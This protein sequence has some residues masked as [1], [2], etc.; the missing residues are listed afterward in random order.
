MNRLKEQENGDRKVKGLALKSIALDEISEVE[1][2]EDNAKTLNMLT[3]KFNKFMKKR[4]KD[5]NQQRKKYTKKAYSNYA[6]FTCFGYGKQGYIEIECPNLM[7]KEKIL[8][9]KNFSKNNKGKRAYIAWDENDSTTSS[10]SKEDEEVNLCLM[11]I[12]QSEAH[13]ISINHKNYNTLLQPFLEIYD[14]A[15]RL[16]LSNNR[17]KNLNN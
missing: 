16:A 13:C 3:R 2:S 15:N 7:D 17:L 4:G 9:K 8:D 11:A 14:E 6:N 12:D 1:S 10:S 5:K